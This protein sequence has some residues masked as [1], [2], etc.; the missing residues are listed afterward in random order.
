MCSFYPLNKEKQLQTHFFYMYIK[1]IK[2]KQTIITPSNVLHAAC[3]KNSMENSRKRKFNVLYVED[4]NYLFRKTR[5]F[6]GTFVY[7]LFEGFL[8]TIHPFG[9]V[10]ITGEGL[11]IMTYTRPLWPFS[12]TCHTF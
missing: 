2:R 6:N 5:L 1:I 3:K 7:L 11:Q 4:G 12:S 8:R 9:D 10:T